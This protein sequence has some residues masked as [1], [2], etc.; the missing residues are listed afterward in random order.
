VHGLVSLQ[1]AEKLNFGRGLEVLTTALFAQ[2]FGGPKT[3]KR[4]S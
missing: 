1:L 2:I 3:S 4:S